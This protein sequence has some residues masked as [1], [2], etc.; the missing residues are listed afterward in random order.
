LITAEMVQSR[1]FLKE[2]T[3]VLNQCRVIKHVSNH[4]LDMARVLLYIN[5]FYQCG[6]AAPLNF[7]QCPLRADRIQNPCLVVR[8]IGQRIDWQALAEQSTHDASRHC[9]IDRSLPGWDRV[10]YWANGD[11]KSERGAVSKMWLAAR[12]GPSS[13]A[14]SCHIIKYIYIYIYI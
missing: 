4:R 5:L 9:K 6:T 11:A 13:E 7:L 1:I 12:D 3:M 14:T 10:G 2:H 8:L